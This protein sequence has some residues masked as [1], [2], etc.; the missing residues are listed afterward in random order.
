MANEFF[1]VL[2][3]KKC[4]YFIFINKKTGLIIDN[5]KKNV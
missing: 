4:E 2:S 1:E 3:F 5:L